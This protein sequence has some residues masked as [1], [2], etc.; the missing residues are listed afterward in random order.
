MSEGNLLGI[1]PTGR[2]VRWDGVDIYRL[3]DGR[4]VEEWAGD[5]LAAILDQVGAYAPKVD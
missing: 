4:I 2:R 1:E 3:A 5:D